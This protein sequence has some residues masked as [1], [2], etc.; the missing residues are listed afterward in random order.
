MK[1]K[2][3]VNCKY[4]LKFN[5]YVQDDGKI[6]SERTNKILSIYLDKDG[7]E[8][9][10]MMST[11]GKRHRYS[12]HR[13]VL[14]NFNPTDGMDKLQVNHIDGNKRNNNLSNLEWVTCSENQIHAHKIGSKNQS[15]EHNN[16]SKLSER[17]VKEIIQLLLEHKYTHAEI[18]RM[19]NVTTEAVGKIKRKENWKYLTKNINFD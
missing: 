16:A 14:E 7:Y 18:A 2:L 13:L 11:D 6:F 3:I 17:E 12:V 10:Q 1:R 4:T 5:Y 15:G 9:V 8:K 19:Y